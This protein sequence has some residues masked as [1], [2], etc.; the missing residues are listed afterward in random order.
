MSLRSLLSVSL[1]LCLA[2]LVSVGDAVC[3]A[4]SATGAVV[5][6]TV[7]DPDAA[8]IPGAT[9]TLTPA[10]G[11]A[12][13][14]TSKADGAYQ[15]PGVTPGTYA[16][17]VTMNGFASYVRQG[18]RLAGTQQMN[19]DVKLAI[20]NQTQQ[21]NVNASSAQVSVDQDNNASSTVIKGKDLDALSDDPD[22]LS[23]ELSALAGP[24]SGPNG[25]QIY[26][27]GFT[28]GQLPP[29]SSI[30]EVRVNQ[31]PFS[32]QYDKPGYGRVEVFTK[33]GTDKF[34]GNYSIQ[35]G[36]KGLNTSNP[37]LGS[38]NQQPN[39]YTLFMIGSIT[40]PVTK[41]SSFNVGGSNRTIQDN[42]IINPTGFYSSSPTSTTLCPPGDLT[43]SNVG[44]YP[45][46]ARA[47]AHIRH[48][49]DIAPRFDL[50]LGEKNTL[51]VRYQYVTLDEQNGGLGGAST[52][53]EAGYSDGTQENTI[54][55]TDTQILSPR[56]INETRFE[57]ERDTSY[58]T[59]NSTTPA[60]SVQGS[61][62]GG[63]SSLGRLNTVENHIELQNYTSVQMAK[64]FLRV[65]G[66]FRT[67]SQASTS[68]A[69]SNGTFTYTSLLDPCTDPTATSRP[70]N[71][72]PATAPCT[73]HV[74]SISSYQC[75]VAS[76]FTITQINQPTITNRLNDVGLYAEDDWK[77]RPN[78]TVTPGVR[79]ESQ[80]NI[81]SGHDVA[82]RVS[83]AFGVPRKGGAP[84]TVLRG[85]YGVFYDRFDQE[86][87]LS[88][89]RLNGFNQAQATVRN[90][91][92]T[93]QPGNEGACAAAATTNSTIYSLAGSLRS[94]YTLE[95]AVGVDQQLGRSTT[96]SVNYINSRGIHE[97]LTRS[98][99]NTGA[100]F[101]Y[102]FQS[103]GVYREN[104][105]FVNLNSRPRHFTIFGFYALS[106]GNS[107]TSGATF[108][109]TDPV[110]PAVDYGRSSFA[111]RNRAVFGGNY[112]APYGFTLAPFL[113]ANSGTP[114]TLTSGT[115]TNG[116]SIF[117]DRPYYAAGSHGNCFNAADFSGTQTG[118]L[119]P[120]P[121]N[122]CL[123]P[124]NFSLNLRLSRVFGF[125]PKLEG[126]GSG[127]GSGPGGPPPGRG[128]GGGGRGPGGGGGP[129]GMGGASTRHRYNVTIGAQA[130]NIFNVIPYA[131]PVAVLASPRFGEFTSLQGG[132]FSS[133][134]AVRRITLQ[135]SFNF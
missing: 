120:V 91:A 8:V 13:T 76:Q 36:L 80:S 55:A 25:G 2:W 66:R 24:S 106:F 15:L 9:I 33:P 65:G 49:S 1:A 129:F 61:F 21:V 127:A 38:L 125:G 135:A 4:Q 88:A 85:G 93:C 77:V 59:P 11:P 29:K 27:D 23:S 84:V 22:D 64:H 70:T 102:Q 95:A 46:S 99:V 79:Y 89:I 12:T 119:T 114:Y 98:L 40:G 87:V 37:F 126:G 100:A 97:Y 7:T 104:Q 112:T 111:V 31:N 78:L 18:V 28:G 123:A 53:P 94:A 133:A 54:R 121:I 57:F 60:V 124:A 134:T 109:A 16:F 75:G 35:G 82:P 45:L 108:F 6:G 50:A 42:N 3:L 86:N 47:L 71:C 41:N 67:T 44:A 63:G 58:Q 17:T 90:P 103:G 118:G 19:I 5:R 30:R 39:Y 32:A 117:N 56:V 132:P 43:C 131:Q 14:T 105:L 48:R 128:P 51:S 20:E 74:A 83:F 73:T 10:A 68:N 81:Q 96:I 122:S 130:F 115:D 110:H 116:D 69:G 26:V 72:T 113:I 107:N 62:V 34:H 52:L 101:N 92:L